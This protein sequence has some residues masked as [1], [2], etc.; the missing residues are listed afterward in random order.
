MTLT[1]L[2]RALATLAVVV[3][4]GSAS[5]IVYNGHAG[6]GIQDGT[7]NTL[8]VGAVTHGSGFIL[9]ADNGG[10]IRGVVRR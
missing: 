9:M 10:Q 8:M 6:L 7:S 5:L 1:T 4:T 2:K 3:V